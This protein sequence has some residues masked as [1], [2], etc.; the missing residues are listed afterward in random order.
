MIFPNKY[1]VRSS[2]WEMA[3]I[4]IVVDHC[5]VLEKKLQI[6]IINGEFCVPSK[7]SLKIIY[8]AV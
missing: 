1:R 5:M 7:T 6:Q 4:F 3:A 2:Q 8:K